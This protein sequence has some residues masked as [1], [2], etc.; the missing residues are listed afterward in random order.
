[1]EGAN[2][3]GITHTAQTGKRSTLPLRSWLTAWVLVAVILAA[4]LTWGRQ[5]RQ[6]PTKASDQIGAMNTRQTA[7]VHSVTHAMETLNDVAADVNYDLATHR[8]G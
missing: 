2:Y 8:C 5:S 4:P 7:Y 6:W 3:P 1:M